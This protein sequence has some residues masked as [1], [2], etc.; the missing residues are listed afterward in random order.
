MLWVFGIAAV[1]ALC[2]VF[3]IL[4]KNSSPERAAE[5]EIQQNRQKILDMI[6][7]DFQKVGWSAWDR[8]VHMAD[9]Q[10][11]RME[12]AAQS[13]TMRL[14]SFDKKTGT[15]I[16]AGESGKQYTVDNSGCSCGDFL[17]R[18]LPCKHMYFAAMSA[19]E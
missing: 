7:R 18:G 5:R 17:H 4:G 16:V 10:Y 9:G 13:K 15:A 14:V 12:R 8:S 1:A 2:F 19:D 3:Y 6:C 11:E